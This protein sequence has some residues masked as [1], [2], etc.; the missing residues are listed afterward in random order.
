MSA[1]VPRRPG[2]RQLAGW[3]GLAQQHVRKSV[4]DGAAQLGKKQNVFHLIRHRPQIDYHGRVQNQEKFLIMRLQ[5]KDLL[6]F[7][8]IQA[9]VTGNVIP[10]HAFSAHSGKDINRRIALAGH[11]DIPLRVRH[12]AAQ[13]LHQ[14]WQAAC[15]DALLLFRQE[16]LMR[17]FPEPVICFDPFVRGDRESR[18]PQ[19]VRYGREFPCIHIAGAAAALHGVPCACTI[20]RDFSMRIQWEITIGFQQHHAFRG[21]LP[22]HLHVLDFILF[23]LFFLLTSPADRG[24]PVSCS[25]RSNPSA[26]RTASVLPPGARTKPGCSA[27]SAASVR[28]RHSREHPSRL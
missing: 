9:Q 14:L 22:Y 8:G 7:G 11:G 27:R 21:N 5:V 26:S 16:D 25:L 24:L 19:S 3:A 17:L 12:H 15:H 20:K 28:P 2:R 18:M 13:V 6:D 4:A 10:I 23:H 1:C